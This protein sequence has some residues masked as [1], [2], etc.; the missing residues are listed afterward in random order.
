M[1]RAAALAG[2]SREH[3]TALV[4]AQ[5]IAAGTLSPADLQARFERELEPHFRAEEAAL[6]P[7]LAAAGAGALAERTRREHDG[8][9]RLLA[10]VL[11]G[12]AAALAAFGGALRDHVRF[13]ERELFPDA[14][15]RLTPTQLQTLATQL[16]DAATPP[17]A[18]A[19]PS[20]LDF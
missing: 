4:L 3:H 14:E 6:L 9:R 15:T 10:L 18:A 12:D 8:M 16:E 19:S 17:P 13:E 5:R 7:L 11:A 1:K 20:H 2:L